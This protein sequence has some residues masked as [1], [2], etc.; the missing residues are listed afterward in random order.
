MAPFAN[1]FLGHQVMKLYTKTGD[2]GQTGLIGGD[3][4]KKDDP[5]VRAYGEVDELNAVLGWAICACNRSEWLDALRAVQSDLFVVGVD[6]ATA[7]TRIPSHTVSAS[8]I[9]DLERWIDAL[10]ADRNLSNFVL[11]GGSEFAARLHVARTV[12]RRAEREVV[13]CL[14]ESQNGGDRSGQTVTYLNRFADLLFALALAANEH[15]GVADIPWIAPP[16]EPTT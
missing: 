7:A 12:C 1:A 15:A 14:R 8:R 4:V 11:P 9:S 13:R 3:R 6:L 2:S 10:M 5:R 16:P